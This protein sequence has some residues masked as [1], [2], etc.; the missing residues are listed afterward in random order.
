[1]CIAEGL[2]WAVALTH[3]CKNIAMLVFLPRPAPQSLPD[4]QSFNVMDGDVGALL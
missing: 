3:G 1:M 2:F 4:P